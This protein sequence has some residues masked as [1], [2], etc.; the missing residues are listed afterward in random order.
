MVQENNK[1]MKGIFYIVLILI[2]SVY[3]QNLKGQDMVVKKIAILVAMEK[4]CDLIKDVAKVENVVVRQCGVGKVNAAMSCVELIRE[5]N[6]DV[7]LSLGCAGGNGDEL[8]IGDVIISSEV[9]Y[10][11]VYCGENVLYGQ[12]QG[13][14]MRYKSPEWIVE[15]ACKIGERV[16]PGLI[17]SGDWF[18]DSKQKMSDILKCFPETKAV[19]M[20]SA[21]IAQVCYKY[22]IPFVSLRIVSDLP[23]S[24]EQNLQYAEFWNTISD[25]TFSVANKFV[26]LL[27][28]KE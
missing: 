1:D 16:V 10:H 19:D 28:T 3:S 2:T 24:K 7:L 27:I 5:H 12:V 20:E 4:E 15:K 6:P 23:M 8:T 14:P 25:K 26:K 11:D 21:A 13:M 17:A 18:V 22:Q 9:V